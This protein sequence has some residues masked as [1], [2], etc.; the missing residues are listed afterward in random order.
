MNATLETYCQY[1]QDYSEMLKIKAPFVKERAILAQAKYEYSEMYRS[2]KPK[3]LTEDK[4]LITRMEQ[5]ITYLDSN[6][7][8]IQA[9]FAAKYPCE[10]E[11]KLY[12]P[13]SVLKFLHAMCGGEERYNA[14]PILDI[15]KQDEKLRGRFDFI[16]ELP[17]MSAAVMRGTDRRKRAFIVVS[18]VDDEI[19]R[20]SFTIFQ[21]FEDYG[22][23]TMTNEEIGPIVCRYNCRHGQ[24]D[25]LN[26]EL[27]RKVHE[28]VTTGQT[29]QIFGSNY[30]IGGTP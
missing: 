11:E 10:V 9:E 26:A 23:S 30:T 16:K 4:E 18:A 13:E 2:D 17:R 6:V 7:K 28:L 27:F 15:K 1:T 22:L 29:T 12:S 25:H 14:V 19:F 20:A 8:K 5:R 3:T 21:R 24:S